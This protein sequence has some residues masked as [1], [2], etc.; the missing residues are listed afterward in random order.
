MNVP[1]GEI[2]ANLKTPDMDVNMAA[3]DASLKVDVKSPKTK[4]PMFGKMYFPDVEFDIKSPKF[5]AEA[6]LPSP[7]LEG[8]IQTPGLEISSPGIKAGLKGPGLEVGS[9]GLS[10]SLPSA[11]VEGPDIHLKAPKFKGPGGSIDFSGPK[12]EGDLKVP[13]VQANLDAS[14]INIEVPDAKIKAPSFGISSPQVSIPDVNVN[15]K[16]PKIKGD[17]PKVELEGPDVDLKGPDAKIQFPKFSLPKI[18][19]PGLKV[20]GGGADFHGQLPSLEGGVSAPNLK[21]EGPDV[22]LRGPQ[23][24]LP[25]VNLSGPDL[26]LNLKGPKL[27]GD[28]DVS[29]GVIGPKVGVDTPGLDL[30]GAG[31]KL[32][33][34]GGGRFST[35]GGV[36]VPGVDISL[37]T[38]KLNVG[39]PD[40]NLKGPNL[41]GDVAIAGDIKCPKGSVDAPAVGLEAPGG[42]IKLPQMKLPQFGISSQGSNLDVN[43]T[44]PELKGPGMDVQ[45][46]GVDGKGPQI[47]P[48][49]D[50]N[51][52]G[53]KIKGGFRASGDIKGPTVGVGLGGVNVKGLE[54]S[55]QKPRCEAELPDVNVKF[56]SGKLSGSG[57]GLH[58]AAPDVSIQGPTFNLSSPEVSA[59][60]LGGI[61]LKGPKI[62][63][64]VD[65]S[66][67][68]KAPDLSLGGGHVNIKGV[69]GEWKGPQ[70]SSALDLDVPKLAGGIHV[71]GPKAEGGIK[72]GQVGLQGPGVSVSSPQVHLESVSGKV[73]FPK[74]KI[75]KFTSSERELVGREVGVDVNFP[76]VEGG[77]QAGADEG[78]WEEADVKLKKSKIKMPKFTFSKAKGKGSAASSPEVSISGSKGDLKSSKAS[79]GSFDGEVEAEA[80]SPKGKFSFFKSKKPRHRSSSFSDEREHSAPVTPTGTL[81]F[82]SGEVSI[83]G[84]KVKGKHGKLKFGTFGGLGSKSKG[85]YEVTGSDE[86]AGKL[87]GSGVSLASKKSRLSSSS[88]NDSGTK[89]GIQLS[90]AELTVSKK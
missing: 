56:P 50:L 29:G 53:P 11:N 61:S 66:G 13:T 72:G 14:D 27:K 31:G 8:E 48:D 35:E 4:K 82:G 75:P 84:G 15:L 17:V 2:D 45:L 28:L 64:S 18:G 76:K 41:K 33:M 5:K 57:I 20:E 12:I 85:H 52:E 86:E 63:G 22:T 10:G 83:E 78:E 54:G 65:V 6:P 38:P 36:K 77:M 79:L 32:K 87:Q 62:Q 60:D 74:M 71:S 70:V 16:G 7:K 39:M 68:D 67:G 24:N 81:E 34:E 30:K 58:G 89:V 9:V 88:S 37:E 23:G 19:V 3:P 43:I 69:G 49:V 46:K 47:S 90:E 59:S 21:F 26:D 44:G 1:E 42:A 73:T 40:V 80:S 51:L 25:S 55:I